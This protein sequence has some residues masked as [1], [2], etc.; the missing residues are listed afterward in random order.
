[1]KILSFAKVFAIPLVIYCNVAYSS[2]ERI[3]VPNVVSISSSQEHGRTMEG[4]LKYLAVK[5]E[6]EISSLGLSSAQLKS[7]V[8]TRPSWVH[9]FGRFSTVKE[10]IAVFYDLPNL[11]SIKIIEKGNYIG[12]LV[13]LAGRP[14][15]G[16]ALYKEGDEFF[17]RG[18]VDSSGLIEAVDAKDEAII[19]NAYYSVAVEVFMA[20]GLKN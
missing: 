6:G 20:N 14:S 12:F 15:G 16:F 17:L 5:H 1:M 2:A 11:Q 8:Y 7:V 9:N 13:K 19:F 18:L 3:D 10:F 4:I